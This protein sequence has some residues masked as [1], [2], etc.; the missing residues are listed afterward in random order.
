MKISRILAF[1]IVACHP[2]F[3]SAGE[4]D[5]CVEITAPVTSVAD[6]DANG[7][8]DS[9]DIAILAKHISMQKRA[10]KYNRAIERS[11]SRDNHGHDRSNSRLSQ[12]QLK[13]DVIYS[14]LFDR[15]ADGEIDGIDLF[16][17]TRDMGQ[18]ST[19]EDRKL[20]TISNKILAGTYSCIEPESAPAVEEPAAI[21][22]EEPAA[23]PVETIYYL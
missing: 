13:Q 19:E 9:K 8:V 18:A 12:R 6:F 3:V 16:M 22:E 1:A 2:L 15:N 4:T 11:N 14:P 5:I 7:I 20:A 21:V 23:P 10:S 17:A